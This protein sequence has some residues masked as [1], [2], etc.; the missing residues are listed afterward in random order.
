[1]LMKALHWVAQHPEPNLAAGD[2]CHA[3]LKA[4]EATIR[5]KKQRA[6][7]ALTFKGLRGAQGE[8]IDARA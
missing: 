8:S 3:A 6:L 1:M 7:S 5:V 4:S 2:T